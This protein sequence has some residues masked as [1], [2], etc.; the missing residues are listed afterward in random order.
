[1]LPSFRRKGEGGLGDGEVRKHFLLEALSDIGK[2]HRRKRP[3]TFAAADRQHKM[4]ESADAGEGRAQRVRRGRVHDKGIDAGQR[5]PR[6]L[7]P[8]LAPPGDGHFVPAGE[9][10]ARGRKSDTRGAADDDRVL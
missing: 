1:M 6:I 4:I 7:E 2:A 5:F 8:N 3:C 9:Q 10:V